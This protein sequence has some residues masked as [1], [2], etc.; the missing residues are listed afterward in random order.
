MEKIL[1]WIDNEIL[2]K[3]LKKQVK[4]LIT[5]VAQKQMKCNNVTRLNIF[6][7]HVHAP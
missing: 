2:S 6:A 4:S 3:E 1:C 7:C 5:F